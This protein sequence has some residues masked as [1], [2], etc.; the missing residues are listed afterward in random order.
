ML[1]WWIAGLII[2]WFTSGRRLRRASRKAQKEN[3]IMLL[4]DRTEHG[5]SG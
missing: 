3:A 2:A 5:K 4:D 1:A